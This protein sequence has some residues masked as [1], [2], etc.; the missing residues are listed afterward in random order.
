MAQFSQAK[1]TQQKYFIN[2]KRVLKTKGV[3][4]KFLL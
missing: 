2:W 4:I 3:G 1:P